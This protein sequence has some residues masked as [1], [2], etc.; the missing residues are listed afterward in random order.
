MLDDG[1]LEVDRREMMSSRLTLD[2]QKRQAEVDD[3]GPFVGKVR[4][5][6]GLYQR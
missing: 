3:G 6:R 4:N 2:N 5:R 1:H